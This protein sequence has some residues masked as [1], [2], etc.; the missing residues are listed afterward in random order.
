MLQAAR[1]MCA[2]RF[3][4]AR[5]AEWSERGP[6]LGT[7]EL[8]FLP[9]REV[10]ALVDL[11]EVDQVAIGAPGPGLRGSIDVLR[12]YRDGHRQRDLGGLLRARTDHAA[13]RAVL[14]VQPP[15]RG[16]AVGQPVERDVVQHVVFRRRLFGIGAVGPLRETRMHE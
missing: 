12:K 9:R 3:I 11:V 1:T 8:G 15:C 13:P 2:W 14:P 16:R 4:S 5:F 10:P 6:E 7:E